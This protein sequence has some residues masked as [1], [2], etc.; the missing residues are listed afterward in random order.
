VRRGAYLPREPRHLADDDRASPRST[1]KPVQVGGVQGHTE[2]VQA[3]DLDAVLTPRVGA[4]DRCRGRAVVNGDLAER[5]AT[6][7]CCRRSNPVRY[8]SK[9]QSASSTRTGLVRSTPPRR[10]GGPQPYRAQHPHRVAGHGAALQRQIIDVSSDRMEAIKAARSCPFT[11][12]SRLC[13]WEKAA[14]LRCRFAPLY[15][16]VGAANVLVIAWLEAPLR[17]K[18]P[19]LVPHCASCSSTRAGKPESLT[20]AARADGGTHR[21]I[22]SRPT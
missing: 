1:G 20:V 21:C 12:V 19:E 17:Q 2:S 5:R 8:Q 22:H 16:S 18:A 7:R 4:S 11:A 13:V 14:T 3:V 6:I 10:E 15:T 9:F